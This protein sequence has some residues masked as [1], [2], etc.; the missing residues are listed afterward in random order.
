MTKYYTDYEIE[1]IKNHWEKRDVVSIA[2]GLGRPVS[3]VICKASR[4]GISKKEKPAY[5]P[6]IEISETDL[7]WAAG[8]I[9]ADGCFQLYEKYGKNYSSRCVSVNQLEKRREVLDSLQAMF[10]GSIILFKK[11]SCTC[12]EVLVWRIHA[13]ADIASMIR[14]IYPYMKCKEKKQK[15]KKLLD[16]C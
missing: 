1:Y 15:A 12:G 14:Q 8:F 6:A 13:K 16:T 11:K 7:A 3:S 4:L 10:G 9:E 5:V 2:E